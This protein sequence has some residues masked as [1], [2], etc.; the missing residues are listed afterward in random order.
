[1]IHQ[2]KMSKIDYTFDGIRHKSFT[3]AGRL[4]RAHIFAKK[5]MSI[6]SGQTQSLEGRNLLV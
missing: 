1:M 4:G 2:L 6:K 3:F 5:G